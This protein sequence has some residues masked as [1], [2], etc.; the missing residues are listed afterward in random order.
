M[1]DLDDEDVVQIMSD[2]PGTS[3]RLRNR[4]EQPQVS[5]DA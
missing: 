3:A 1:D 4:S 5:T 2:D